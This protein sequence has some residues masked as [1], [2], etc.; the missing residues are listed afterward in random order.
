MDHNGVP[1]S[2]HVTND[3]LQERQI[4]NQTTKNNCSTCCNIFP[5]KCFLDEYCSIVIKN[6]LSNWSGAYYKKVPFLLFEIR[7]YKTQDVRHFKK[8]GLFL[9]PAALTHN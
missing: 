1:N 8:Q 5:D 4:T 7:H 3:D 2:R 6:G 9:V